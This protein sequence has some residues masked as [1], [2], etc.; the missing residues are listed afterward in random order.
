MKKQKINSL[1]IYSNNE[2]I[3]NLSKDSLFKF[4]YHPNAKSILGLHYL[5]KSITYRSNQLPF[6]FSQFFPEGDLE[7]KFNQAFNPEDSPFVNNDMLK[8]AIYGRKTLGRIHVKSNNSLLNEWLDEAEQ[9][10]KKSI[11]HHQYKSLLKD[12]SSKDLISL[13]G[14]QPKISLREKLASQVKSDLFI[15]KSFAPDLY[16]CMAA[17]EFLCMK[18]IKSLNIP[19]AEVSLSDDMSALFIKRFDIDENG[20]ALGMEDFTSIK[21]YHSQDKYKGSYSSIARLIQKLSS[22]PED[23]L[24]YFFNQIAATCLL[25]NGDAHLKNF[26]LI[27]G[28]ENNIRLAPAYDILDTSIY[29]IQAK[30]GKVIYDN[31]LALNLITGSG[32]SY[33]TELQLITFAEKYC[34]IN[35]QDAKWIIENIKNT[36]ENILK[37]YQDVLIKNDWL[38]GKWIAKCKLKL[39]PF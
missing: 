31:N 24:L 28:D 8:L 2:L 5:D 13:S 18:I 12:I 4:N 27:Y 36:K 20:L 11:I 19:T 30:H 38:Y 9:K 23:D 14:F 17:N 21:N 10:L 6:I 25:K 33:P 29:A 39:K 34:Q 7:D 16:P 32:R 37:E 15:I 3:G 26:S 1:E 35:K 22:S